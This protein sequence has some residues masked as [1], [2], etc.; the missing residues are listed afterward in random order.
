MSDFQVS[1]LHVVSEIGEPV[2]TLTLQ[3]I[4]KHLIV[5]EGK[6]KLQQQLMSSR[7]LAS[8]TSPILHNLTHNRASFSMRASFSHS[9]EHH[10]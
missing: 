1:S 10:K 8:Q 9:F 2:G 6:M 5:Q 4:C 3:D 7:S